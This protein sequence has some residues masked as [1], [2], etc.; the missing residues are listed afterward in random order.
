MLPDG[1]MRK[2]VGGTV[3][4]EGVEFFKKKKFS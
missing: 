3:E 4:W 2:W 1:T